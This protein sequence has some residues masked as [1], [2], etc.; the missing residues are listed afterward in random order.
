MAYTKHDWQ[1]GETITET[2]LDHMEQGIEDA[3]NI[4][5]LSG[6]AANIEALAEG[7]ELAVVVTKV[8][9]LI[10]QLGAR[11]V[12]APAAVQKAAAKTK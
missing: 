11:G 5:G 6:T 7:A 3:N 2:L 9:E 10:T 8:N 4:V 12:L 1:T